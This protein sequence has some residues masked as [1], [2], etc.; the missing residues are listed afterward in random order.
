MI[1]TDTPTYVL[2][3]M[4]GFQCLVKPVSLD[5]TMRDLIWSIVDPA[6][7]FEHTSRGI[8]LRGSFLATDH[9]KN[10]RS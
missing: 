5:V 8:L 9:R 3:Y 4:G 10:T 7:D 1:H 6:D 2:A